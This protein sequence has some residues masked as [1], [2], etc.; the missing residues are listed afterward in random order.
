MAQMHQINEDDLAT[1]ERTL[2]QVADAMSAHLDN[3]TRVQLRQVQ[4]ILS[5][6]RWSY[7][8]LTDVE[9]VP[10]DQVS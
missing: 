7:G 1:L 8:P 5:R 4:A 10:G 2:P 3:R 6:V 9:N